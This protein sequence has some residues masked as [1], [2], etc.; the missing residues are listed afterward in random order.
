MWKPGDSSC[1]GFDAELQSYATA[2]SVLF[3]YK[4]RGDKIGARFLFGMKFAQIRHTRF[5]LGGA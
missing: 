5:S 2:T 1:P 3:F 4:N